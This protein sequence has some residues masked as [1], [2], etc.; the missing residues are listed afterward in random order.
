MKMKKSFTAVVLLFCFF[1]FGQKEVSKKVNTN[2]D[3]I[4]SHNI[5]PD[6]KFS[7]VSMRWSF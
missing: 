3:L 1:A 6:Q 5:K 7:Q 2:R 4:L